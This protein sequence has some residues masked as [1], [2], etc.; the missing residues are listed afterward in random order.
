M[1][2]VPKEELMLLHLK[3]VL[4]NLKEFRLYQLKTTIRYHLLLINSLH[5]K[6]LQCIILSR[7]R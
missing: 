7:M 1:E 4:L 5:Y 2:A 3:I 6:K